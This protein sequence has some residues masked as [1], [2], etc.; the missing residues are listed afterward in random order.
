MRNPFVIAVGAVFS[1]L[2]VVICHAATFTAPLT[3][4]ATSA[5]ACVNSGTNLCFLYGGYLGGSSSAPWVNGTN[6]FLDFTDNFINQ[7]MC[8]R[9]GGDANYPFNQGY[10][11]PDT[12]RGNS[13]TGYQ[14][15]ISGSAPCAN[16]MYY[17]RTQNEWWLNCTTMNPWQTVP[18]SSTS[19][20]SESQNPTTSPS[21]WMSRVCQMYADIRTAIPN[22]KIDFYAPVTTAEQ[23]F[24]PVRQGQCSFDFYELHLYIDAGNYG[25]L[26]GSQVWALNDFCG[27]APP[28]ISCTASS[29]LGMLAAESAQFN[30]PIISNEWCSAGFNDTASPDGT[31]MGTYMLIKWFKAN[32]VVGTQYWHDVDAD[33]CDPNGQG[34]VTQALINGLGS[35]HYAGS[36][37]AL[38]PLPSPNPWF[39]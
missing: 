13:L 36:T 38:I 33:N 21:T 5:G 12:T 15:A 17:A 35:T 16:R 18:G 11:I 24:D 1:G 27:V 6:R 39:P 2:L 20:S 4:T 22:V 19:C 31:D 28:S 7:D 23:A 8:N 30:K 29:R 9:P 32:N 3:G 26:T 14:T 25:G 10:E 34:N 37:F